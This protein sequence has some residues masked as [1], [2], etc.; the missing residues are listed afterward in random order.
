MPLHSFSS[1]S[2]SRNTPKPKS[3]TLNTRCQPVAPL[4]DTPTYGVPRR[5]TVKLED[6]SRKKRHLKQVPNSNKKATPGAEARV[7]TTRRERQCYDKVTANAAAQR[8]CGGNKARRRREPVRRR[9]YSGRSTCGR[10]PARRWRGGKKSRAEDANTA[11][12]R[13]SKQY[14]AAVTAPCGHQPA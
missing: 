1:L 12:R 13:D 4:N 10:R 5:V 9:Q 7:E 6:L 14:C 8:R 3:L 2:L 11:A